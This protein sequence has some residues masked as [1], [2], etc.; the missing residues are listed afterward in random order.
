ML[1]HAYPV[2]AQ[3]LQPL[4]AKTD[5][6]RDSVR[7]ASSVAELKQLTNPETNDEVRTVNQNMT[8]LCFSTLNCTI[9]QSLSAKP[10][11]LCRSHR[12]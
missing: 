8:P 11:N 12:R 6:I 5:S 7:H 3:A 10:L 4:V 9:Q 1:Y 2:D